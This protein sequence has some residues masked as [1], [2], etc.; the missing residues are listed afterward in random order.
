MT[1]IFKHRFTQILLV[2]FAAASLC[3][4]NDPV[5]GCLDVAATNFDVNA[6]ENCCCIYPKLILDVEQN[7]GDST[8]YLPEGKYE[9]A[10]GQWL[11]L[12]SVA[13]YLADFQLVQNGATFRPTDSLDL[14]VFPDSLA[15]KFQNDFLLVR[16]TPGTLP[17]GTFRQADEFSEIRFVVGLP[18]A[19]RQV[20]PGLAP[21]GHALRSPLS[22]MWNSG[23]KFAFAQVVFARDTATGTATDTLNFFP[24]DFPKI[25]FSTTPA[26]PLKHKTGYDFHVKLT[27]DFKK[28]FAGL[29]LSN[30]D[31]TA[32]KAAVWANLPASFSVSQ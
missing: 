9:Y 8:V 26:L 5:K 27:V 4:C 11:R 20:V 28:W 13:F 17:I 22:G 7:F 16:R 24:P 14:K 15:Q 31:P 10:P 25:D 6:D 30:A 23:Q 32:I 3:S 19:A 21:T 18:D 12:N 2:A 1:Q 29:D